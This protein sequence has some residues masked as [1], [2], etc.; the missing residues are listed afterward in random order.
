VSE[1]KTI[2]C[3]GKE[4]EVT[5]SDPLGH[6]SALV[7][8]LPEANER[9]L[10]FASGSEHYAIRVGLDETLDGF[11]NLCELLRIL[12]G[13]GRKAEDDILG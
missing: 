3:Q 2:Q 8:N 7:G 1:K 5:L 13:R 6:V 4:W 12:R 10:R 9:A 11:E